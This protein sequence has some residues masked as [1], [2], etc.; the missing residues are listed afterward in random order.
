MSTA[1]EASLITASNR[2]AL[3]SAMEREPRDKA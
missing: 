2:D 3:P 1:A